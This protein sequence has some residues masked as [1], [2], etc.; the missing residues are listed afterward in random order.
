MSYLKQA[1]M[2]SWDNIYFDLP[3]LSQ[4]L[5]VLSQLQLNY[6][7]YLELFLSLIKLRNYSLCES[8]IK[9]FKY[10]KLET[11][12]TNKIDKKALQIYLLGISLVG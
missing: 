3:Y 11:T 10:Q 9:P 4:E 2:E 8:L 7:Y 6:L 1:A 5:T 12:T